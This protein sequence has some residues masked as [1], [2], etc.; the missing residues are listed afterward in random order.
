[1]TESACL[2]S[3]NMSKKLEHKIQGRR[4]IPTVQMDI[5]M[6]AIDEIKGNKYCSIRRH[7]QTMAMYGIPYQH[8]YIKI[9]A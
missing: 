9:Q 6:N 5:T 8:V 1:M 3:K 2:E 4:N 7:V